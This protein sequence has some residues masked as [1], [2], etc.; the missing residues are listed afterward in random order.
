[1]TFSLSN[2]TLFREGNLQLN[3]PY[4]RDYSLK[5]L[6][7][8]A[9]VL[10]HRPIVYDFVLLDASFQLIEGLPAAHSSNNWVNN[11]ALLH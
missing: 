6:Q 4:N 5:T 11:K 9:S 8:E 10:L 7:K 1:M 2:R 3:L